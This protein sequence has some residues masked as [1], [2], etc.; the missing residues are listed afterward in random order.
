M[1]AAYRGPDI[2][3]PTVWI[4]QTTTPPSTAA[5]KLPKWLLLRTAAGSGSALEGRT[6][7]SGSRFGKFRSGSAPSRASER[8]P[9]ILESVPGLV[10]ELMKRSTAGESILTKN[11]TIN[12]A[13]NA[14]AIVNIGIVSIACS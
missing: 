6:I 2:R 3:F 10:R 8:E 1:R 14:I 11:R 9:D 12:A 5:V 13:E 7:V 4:V